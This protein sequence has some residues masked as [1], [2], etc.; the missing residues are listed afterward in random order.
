MLKKSHSNLQ[1]F[2]DVF[3][4]ELQVDC[5]KNKER[6]FFGTA[7]TLKV[8]NLA[9]SETAAEQWLVFQLMDLCA[10]CGVKEKL[11]ERQMKQ[12]AYIIVTEYGYLKVTEILLFL[13]RFKAGKYGRFYGSIDPLIIMQALDDFMDERE[14]AIKKQNEIQE[15]QL[16][17]PAE[18]TISPQ[19][20]CRQNGFTEVTSVLDVWKIGNRIQ[21]IIGAILWFINM[22][23]EASRLQKE[24]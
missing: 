3:K 2:S 16:P 4:P 20:W 23:Y 22:I 5:A 15:A 19:E 17:V 1:A 6:A 12:L 21:D 10:Y 24:T 13:H 9:Y 7:P 11:N 18:D 14:E 8:L